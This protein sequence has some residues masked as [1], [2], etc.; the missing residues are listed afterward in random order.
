MS[1]MKSPGVGHSQGLENP[2]DRLACI[3]L[4]DEMKVIG[5]QTVAEQLEPVTA[6]GLSQHMKESRVIALLTEDV[7]SV[8]PAI[9]RVIDQAF[10]DRTRQASHDS[11]LQPTAV[12]VK[13]KEL[14]PISQKKE[15]TP[16]S[17]LKKELTPISL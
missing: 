4:Q 9:E 17:L 7:R 10:I 1:L 11:K 6:L 12:G 16:I 2:T 8:V 3:R 14:T 5:H 15:L 13:K